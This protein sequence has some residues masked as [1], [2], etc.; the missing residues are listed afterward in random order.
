M[1]HRCMPSLVVGA[2]TGSVLYLVLLLYVHTY[3][4]HDSNRRYIRYTSKGQPWEESAQHSKDQNT[5][6]QSKTG[7]A[8]ISPHPLPSLNSTSTKHRPDGYCCCGCG[9][10]LRTSQRH[11]VSF[12]PSANVDRA[13]FSLCV[14]LVPGS[15]TLLLRCVLLRCRGDRA[16]RM[17]S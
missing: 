14:V 7:D 12:A 3:L 10:M 13:R 17:P 6:K 4:V 1:L 2:L 11:I 8:K 5:Q 15:A 9:G 16:S